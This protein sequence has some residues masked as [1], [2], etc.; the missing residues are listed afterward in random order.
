MTE[1]PIAA[2][3]TAHKAAL[4]ARE[5]MDTAARERGEAIRAAFAA[6]YTAPQLAEALGVRHAQRIYAMS[7]Q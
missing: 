5:A 4:A 2:A 6:G 3:V 7:K 1:D